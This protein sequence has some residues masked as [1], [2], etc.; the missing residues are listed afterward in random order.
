M[1]EQEV[2]CNLCNCYPCFDITFLWIISCNR[3]DPRQFIFNWSNDLLVRLYLPCNIAYFFLYD[4]WSWFNCHGHRWCMCARDNGV[5][6][7]IDGVIAKHISTDEIEQ[8]YTKTAMLDCHTCANYNVKCEPEKNKFICEYP[9]K[10]GQNILEEECQAPKVTTIC[11]KDYIC[12]KD[13]KEG[14]C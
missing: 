4:N 13:Y 2:N 12:I 9:Q 7:S 8:I 3:L 14:N 6:V 10:K 11:G 5:D 1:E